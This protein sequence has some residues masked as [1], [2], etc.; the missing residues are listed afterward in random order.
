MTSRR[1]ALKVL[2]AGAGLAA[3]G[4]GSLVHAQGNTVTITSLGGKW[5]QSI[6]EHFIPLFKQRTGA[7][8]RVVLG[9]PPQWTAQIEA[10]PNN[11]PLDA[12]DNAE[13]FAISLA[14]KGLVQKLTVDKVPNLADTPDIFRKPFDD[15]GA[16]YQYSTSGIFYNAEKIK[17]P[18]TSW[19][20]FFERAGK[21]EFG[22]T[23]T[24]P[25]VSYAWAPFFIWHYAVAQGGG[26]ENLDPAYAGLKKMRPSLVK[27]WT[28][29]LEVER[30]IVSKE[31][32]IGVLWDGRVHAL[33]AG[34]APWLKFARLAPHSLVT[35]TPAQV[36]KG[37]NE[38]LAFEWV[39][40][41]LDPEPQ[42]KYFK[43]INFTPT[44]SKVVIPEDMRWQI[45]PLD[46]G[47]TPPL[48]DLAKA[49][50]GM[51]QRWN[52]ELRG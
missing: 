46:K 36:V 40:T 2:G 51:V 25:D 35:L 24:L 14:D 38:K 49:A 47:V 41:L 42:L 4:R 17:N 20:E 26:M 39:N 18:P 11:P 22:K 31:V 21:G 52:R 8:V 33:M 19:S 15:F 13:L 7:E 28:T 44:N 9:A 12:V 27:F 34:A 3:W 32:D 30:M 10:Q 1:D 45:M 43:L 16:S 29:A 6:R 37:G 50:P 23:V 5:E 48:R